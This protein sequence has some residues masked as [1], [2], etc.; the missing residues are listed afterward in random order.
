MAFG[1]EVRYV[2]GIVT[3][4]VLRL[5]T[6]GIAVGL[7]GACTQASENQTDPNPVPA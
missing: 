5:V 1:D 2:L 4:E 6:V 3:E 7:S